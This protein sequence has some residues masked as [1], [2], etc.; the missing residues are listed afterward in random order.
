MALIYYGIAIL[1]LVGAGAIV[2]WI[3]RSE[4]E[5]FTVGIVV[6]VAALVILG[7][8]MLGAGLFWS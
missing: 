7:V 2:Y 1:S 6:M 8:T 5:G 3:R 4:R